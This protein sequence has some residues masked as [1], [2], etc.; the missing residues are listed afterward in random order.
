MGPA[1]LELP[2]GAFQALRSAAERPAYA[3]R[4]WT[5]VE[6]PEF[7]VK[8]TWVGKEPLPPSNWAYDTSQREAHLN[9]LR[10]MAGIPA[11]P[12][13]TPEFRIIQAR[14][15][16]ASLRAARQRRRA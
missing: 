2:P 7:G 9:W 16:W 11:P 5:M 13:P 14:D 15:D 6:T 12:E 3:R 10:E 8:S 1:L 4:Y